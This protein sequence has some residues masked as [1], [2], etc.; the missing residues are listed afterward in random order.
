[1]GNHETM[2]RLAVDPATTREDAIDALETWMAN[3]GDRVIAQFVEPRR[4]GR[5]DPARGDSRRA[6]AP[7]RA[8]LE[9]LR[10]H[11]RSG[12]ILFVHA[13]VNPRLDLEAFLATPWNTPLR[14]D[15][16][17]QALGV[18]A[19]ALPRS[20]ARP[21]RAGAASSSCTAT[22][23]TTPRPIRVAR[24]TNR[25]FRLNLDAGSGLTGVAEMAIIRGDRAEVV[26]AR[27][28]TNRML[29]G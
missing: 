11:W 4:A 29:R 19:L 2:M 14:R 16:R 8:W 13:G 22:P 12:E 7:R 18:G 6:A 15:R 26:A 24:R 10:P 5:P 27:G 9:N 17:E 28:P 23:P 25:C 20:R 3:G 21:G 1:M